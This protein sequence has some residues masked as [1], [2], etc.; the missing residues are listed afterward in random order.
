VHRG[1]DGVFPR[2]GPVT[3]AAP[4]T[5]SPAFPHTRTGPGPFCTSDP[6]GCAQ[7]RVRAWGT[8]PPRRPVQQPTS[9]PATAHPRAA[10]RRGL[11]RSRR[12]L[13]TAGAGRQGRG[14]PLD[15]QS[16]HA[17]GWGL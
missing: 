1:V 8:G 10:T 9:R 3:G 12:R 7:P 11:G 14:H 6:H 2:Q 15:D 4:A 5:Q 16:A 17:R 13:L